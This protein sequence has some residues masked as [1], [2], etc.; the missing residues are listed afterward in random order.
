MIPPLNHMVNVIISV[1]S[2]LMPN[3]LQ[4]KGYAAMIVMKILIAVPATI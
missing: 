2:F 3:S 1:K 4:D